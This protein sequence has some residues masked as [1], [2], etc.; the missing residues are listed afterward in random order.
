[1]AFTSAAQIVM[2][3]SGKDSAKP[4]QA[5]FEVWVD[6]V[7]A[8]SLAGQRA[9]VISS[10]RSSMRRGALQI[11]SPMR[12]PRLG[13]T[14]KQRPPPLNTHLGS[15]MLGAE[16]LAH[17][18]PNTGALAHNPLVSL[19]GTSKLQLLV[20]RKIDLFI[21]ILANVTYKMLMKLNAG[22]NSAADLSMAF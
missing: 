11:G 2:L 18:R 4:K 1:M 5:H 16:R 9:G 19:S 17:T 12:R 14:P 20:A 6:H 10:M 8:V 21:E 15:P 7:C 22:G 13:T 3:W